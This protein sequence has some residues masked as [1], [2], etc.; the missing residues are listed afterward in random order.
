MK[1]LGLDV[2]T[3]RTGVAFAD[4]DDDLL[5][6][7]ETI[8]HGSDE[9]L[10]DAVKVIFEDKQVDEAVLGLPRLPSGEEGLQAD[11]VRNFAQLLTDEGI[12]HSFV[13]ERYTTPP[14]GDIDTDAAAACQILA[15]KIG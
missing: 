1:Y 2:G 7:L 4:S 3:K 11:L 9:E 12:P 6:S 5:F 15:I 8:H 10:L 13:D 14:K